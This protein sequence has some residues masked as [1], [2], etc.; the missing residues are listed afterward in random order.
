MLITI[1]LNSYVEMTSGGCPTVY[2]FRDEGTMDLYRFRLR[3]G[4][5]SLTNTSVRQLIAEGEFGDEMNG[6]CSINE[7]IRELASAGVI[8]DSV[9]SSIPMCP[10]ID[11]D[12]DSLGDEDAYEVD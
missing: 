7:M 9:K 10:K 5:W 1:K 6:S 11:D 4:R 2:E 3:F 8:L 12:D